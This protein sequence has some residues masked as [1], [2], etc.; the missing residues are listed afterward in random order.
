M[1][2]LRD[3]GALLRLRDFRRL[4]GT[5]LTS[6]LS[7]GVFQVALAGHVFFS[8]EKQTSAADIAAAFAV[9]LLPYSL[10]GPFTGVLLDRWRRRQV[11]VRCNL[12]RAVLVAVTAALVLAEVPDPVF[13]TSCLL[14]LS[15]NRFVLAGL[16]AS[17]P[18]VVPEERLVLANA[19]SPTA[20]TVAA[21]AGALAAVLVHLFLDEGPGAT[22]LVILI[23]GALYLSSAAVAATM[24]VDL[25]GPD[26]DRVVPHVREAVA[27]VARGLREGAAHVWQRRAPAHALAAITAM[28]FCFGV[29]TVM[30]LL[31]CRNLFN[32][33]AD[34]DA[35]LATL[36]LTVGVTAAGF[37]AAAVLTPVVTPRLGVPR[38]IVLCALTGAVGQVALGLP[39]R[40]GPM[41]AA[42]FLLGLVSQ[43][44]KIGVDTVVQT[45][46]D[47]AFRGRVFSVYDVLFNVAFV[48]AAAASALVL[49]SDGKS[50]A[51][52]AA[53]A[54]G[55]AVTGAAYALAVRRHPPRPLP[56][57][58]SSG[59]S[60]N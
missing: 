14:V 23:S 33:P 59:I 47:D 48:G 4:F 58:D 49:P 41:L 13:Y 27:G 26:P 40:L 25:L 30:T 36:G 7:D 10:V 9:L 46:V 60:S 57:V 21:S 11:L 8:P 37:F 1:A 42:G 24:P 34:T 20:G 18:R 43:G 2:L 12:L 32:D 28:R 54:A 22:A 53:V 55:Y 39:F 44:A 15:V 3:L 35:G 5:R 19:V 45:T 50:P 51:V 29:L 6:Q 38:W 52:L 16:S 17:L 56:Q 31:L